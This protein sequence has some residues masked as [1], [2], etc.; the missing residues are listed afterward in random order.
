MESELRQRRDALVCAVN[1]HDVVAMRGFVAPEYR[2]TRTNGIVYTLESV[3]DGLVKM[4]WPCCYRERVA[5]LDLAICDD[6]ARLQTIRY[7]HYLIFWPIWGRCET[8]IQETW[9][10]RDGL[11]MLSEET[12]L[13]LRKRMGVGFRW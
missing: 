5:I 13:S 7:S 6:V 2:G 12:E 3:F 11:W 1:A 8:L 10:R 9:Q 4:R